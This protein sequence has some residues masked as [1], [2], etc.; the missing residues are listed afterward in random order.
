M[1]ADPLAV[2]YLV[3][4]LGVPDD[5]VDILGVVPGDVRDAELARAKVLA[6]PAIG[7]ESFGLVLVEAMAAATP[8]VASDI[9]GYREVVDDEA[10][11]VLVPSGDPDVLAVAV[12]ELL[13]DEERRRRLGE[14]GR[15]LVA[16]RYSWSGIA[17][18][19]VEVYR[20]V[21]T[22]EI[23]ESEAA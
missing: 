14:R 10:S 6:A 21:T 16:A 23:R 18:R 3:R 13:E 19:L 7:G 2:R 15:E 20:G 11:G 22:G 5:G 8:V 9:P 17:S 1:G 12:S 4:R